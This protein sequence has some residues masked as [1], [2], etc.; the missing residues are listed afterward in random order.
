MGVCS[1]PVPYLPGGE[2]LSIEE[3]LGHPIGGE[4]G[5]PE[6]QG[7]RPFLLWWPGSLGLGGAVLAA[8]VLK[9][10]VQFCTPRHRCRR[11]SWRTA[12]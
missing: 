9:D 3:E 11:R 7:Y 10:N 12:R 8:G 2:Q 1:K 5:I 4:N 6:P